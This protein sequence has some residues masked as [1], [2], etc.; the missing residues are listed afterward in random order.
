[1]I[2]F[3]RHGE[4]QAN[5]DGMIAGWLDSPL[6][7]AGQHYAEVEAARLAAEGYNFDVIYSSTLS[8]ARRTAEA[9]AN[10]IGYP[11]Q[12]IQIDPNLREKSL[13]ELD[14]SPK[15]KVRALDIA[16]YVPVGGESDVEFYER[17][18]RFNQKL[19][20]EQSAG[21]DILIV[22][23]SGFYRMAMVIKQ[24][25]APKDFRAVEPPLN[26]TLLDYPLS[27]AL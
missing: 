6:T 13:G 27:G 20:A 24:G 19:E 8:R 15:A 25:L 5:R 26:S 2:Y 23:H 7:E 1:M 21:I 22:G 18:L 9:I 16:T 10:A 17:V 4:S 3:V 14:G 11:I 12:N